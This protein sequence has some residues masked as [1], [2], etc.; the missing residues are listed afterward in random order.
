MAPEIVSALISGTV[1]AIAALAAIV[2]LLPRFIDSRMKAREADDELKRTKLKEELQLEL[3][4]RKNDLENQKADRDLMQS[5]AKSLLKLPEAQSEMAKAMQATASEISNQ[6]AA[7]GDM[8][9]HLESLLTVGSKPVQDIQKALSDATSELHSIKA[10]TQA[11]L[12]QLQSL[13]ERSLI[14]ETT[15]SLLRQITEEKI[16]QAKKTKTDE[17][18]PVVSVAPIQVDPNPIN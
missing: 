12:L 11:G 8:N 6:V 2:Q 14:W 5:M 10:D 3:D 1:V 9:T 18:P 16:Q 17:L 13:L 7:L 4:E 15:A